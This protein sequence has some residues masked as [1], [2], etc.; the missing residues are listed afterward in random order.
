MKINIRNIRN[1][2]VILILIY[3]WFFVLFFMK[4]EDFSQLIPTLIFIGVSL[5]FGVVFLFLHLRFRCP[6]CHKPLKSMLYHRPSVCSNCSAQI[7]WECQ[8]NEN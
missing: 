8:E 4:F 3:A 5:V 7:D 2:S 6:H 1:I